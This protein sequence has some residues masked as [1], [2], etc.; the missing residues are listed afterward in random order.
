MLQEQDQGLQGLEQVPSLQQELPS[1]ECLQKL[2]ELDQGLQGLQE[3]EEVHQVRQAQAAQGQPW[4]VEAV[5][6][7][8]AGPE[9]VAGDEGSQE[10]KA[11][12]IQRMNI[13]YM[14]NAR[15]CETDRTDDCN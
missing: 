9:Q 6:T 3:L 11:L 2:Q 10:P 15:I 8:R 12:H 14:S 13:C 1:L 5:G 4:S 7:A